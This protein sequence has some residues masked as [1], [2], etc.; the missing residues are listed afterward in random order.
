MKITRI[1]AIPC[2][3]PFS[4]AL[5]FASG[6]AT[7]SDTVL[8]RL[9]TDEGLVGV[10]EAPARSY[11]YGETQVSIVHALQ[12]VLGPSLVGYDPL[13]REGVRA[14]LGRTAG[15]NT[16]KG[17]VDLALWDVVGKALG[18]SCSTLLG[19]FQESVRVCHMLGFAAA[20]TMVEEALRVR[21]HHG[22]TTFKVKVGPS[23][24]TCWP[25]GRCALRWA[26]TSSSTS[27]PTEGGRRT[28]L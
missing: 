2:A 21:E 23:R 4:A 13:A 3:I 5:L 16:A 28:R 12:E 14:V 8:V 17:A 22:V 25:A 19:G 26:R 9:H 10:A 27:T 15:N 24:S 11:M 1:E 18:Q 6:E 7:S 20:D